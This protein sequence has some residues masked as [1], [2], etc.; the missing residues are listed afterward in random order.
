MERAEKPT[1]KLSRES[2]RGREDKAGN[3]DSPRDAKNHA[4]E[5]KKRFSVT[6]QEFKR[7]W[8]GKTRK[9]KIK[10]LTEKERALNKLLFE[11]FK[12][13]EDG[14]LQIKKPLTKDD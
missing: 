1:R 11:Q 7:L 3:R 6:F 8:T 9:E 2:A 14:L 13:V 4:R 10:A 5:H 12:A